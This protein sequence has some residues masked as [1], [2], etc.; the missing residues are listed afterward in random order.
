MLLQVCRCGSR[1][2]EV[3]QFSPFNS[4]AI[5]W[6]LITYALVHNHTV[7]LQSIRCFYSFFRGGSWTCASEITR[8]VPKRHT[9]KQEPYRSVR[10]FK[11]TLNI[12][13]LFPPPLDTAC[14]FL[15]WLYQRGWGGTVPFSVDLV[16]CYSM[17]HFFPQYL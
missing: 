5:Y 10:Q 6:L 16:M 12:P 8:T 15:V 9:V 3:N 1:F 14:F 17:I 13:N 2:Q 11:S 4:S 7:N